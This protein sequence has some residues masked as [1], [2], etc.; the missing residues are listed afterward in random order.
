MKE[1]E[2]QVVDEARSA[3]GRARLCGSRREQRVV[4]RDEVEIPA[5][6][7]SHCGRADP[8]QGGRGGG[9]WARGG[10]RAG[11]GRE[12]GAGRGRLC[13]A[14]DSYSAR[15]RM[16]R[17]RICRGPVPEL[18][19]RRPETQ[20]GSSWEHNC[21]PSRALILG[22]IHRGTWRCHLPLSHYAS[23]ART[24]P[25]ILHGGT[26]EVSSRTRLARPRTPPV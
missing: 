22:G 17:P 14:L 9:A 19:A 13:V 21:P 26:R 25:L 1:L 7:S 11:G 18:G 23:S 5:T 24:S 16:V 3:S 12:E 4:G 20:R 8:I 2:R 15:P 10:R 6:R